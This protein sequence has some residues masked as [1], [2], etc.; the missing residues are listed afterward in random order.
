MIEILGNFK[1]LR[2]ANH[3]RKDYISLLSISFCRYYG[4]SLDLMNMFLTLFSPSECWAFL[5][6]NE[7]SRPVTIR[8][9]TLK[10]R[11]RELA[12]ILINDRGINLDPLADWSREGLTIVESEVPIGATPEYLAGYYMIQSAASLLPVLALEINIASEN[13]KKMVKND[14]RVLDMAAAPGGKTTHIGQLM[15]GFGVLVASDINKERL[16][17]VYGNIHR[18]GIK[19]CIILN[20]DGRGLY[21][22]YGG[23][24]DR[25]LLDAPCSCLGVISRDAQI[26]Y[27]KGFKD[28]TTMSTLQKELILSAIDCCKVGGIVVY[29]TCSV[30][31]YE[32]E[33]VVYH[34][35]CHRYVCVCVCMFVL[36]L[37]GFIYCVNLLF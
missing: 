3:S 17:A 10:I 29:S 5:E 9:N 12:K 24:F 21:K 11:R 19:N 2:D 30:S 7:Q 34:A 16:K 31:P 15:K 36:V 6:A 22:Q 37:I 14:F 35:L 18:M 25:V 4:Y 28:V 13:P 8:C 26:K 32:N 27:K 1:T 20:E 33:A 23:M